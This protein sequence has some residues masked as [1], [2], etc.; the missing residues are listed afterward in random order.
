MVMMTRQAALLPVVRASGRYGPLGVKG[1]ESLPMKGL[2]D[3]WR[4][5]AHYVIRCSA[6]LPYLR[7]YNTYD[8][9]RHF[10]HSLP[11]A[12]AYVLLIDDTLDW[13]RK[14]HLTTFKLSLV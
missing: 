4:R 9:T 12:T 5:A 7:H 14:L 11:D 13:H 3:S 10:Q 2:R 8:T 6:T 1:Y